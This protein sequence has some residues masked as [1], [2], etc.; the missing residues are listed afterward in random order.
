MYH[1]HRPDIVETDDIICSHEHSL[2]KRDGRI[3]LH[4]LY[5][6]RPDKEYAD[7]VSLHVTNGAS[8]RY[9]LPEHNYPVPV[10]QDGI[11]DA[12]GEDATEEE[13]AKVAEEGKKARRGGKNAS[14]AS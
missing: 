8:H 11:G 6:L 7:E 2:E 9:L 3:F 5:E 12:F 13:E 4:A 1:T 14:T 10:A